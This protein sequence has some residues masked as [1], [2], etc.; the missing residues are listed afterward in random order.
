MQQETTKTTTTS[1]LNTNPTDL[2]TNNVNV[3]RENVVVNKD[4]MA[5]NKVN[6]IVW[7]VIGVIEALLIVRFLLL[8][9]GANA[10]G[11]VSFIYNLSYPFVAPFVGIFPLDATG[12]SYFDTATIVAMLVWALLGL[13]ITGVI[14]LLRKNEV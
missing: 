7:F 8:L 5:V 9:L 10:T 4:D 3:V 6:S 11:F 2:Q 1:T 13:L 12:R 14:N